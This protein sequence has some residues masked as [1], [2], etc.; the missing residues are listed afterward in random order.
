[1]QPDISR[2][3]APP[4]LVRNTLAERIRDAMAFSSHE[5]VRLPN[6]SYHCKL[7]L[8]RSS[9]QRKHQLEWLNSLCLRG[10]TK[11]PVGTQPDPSHH[12]SSRPDGLVWCRACGSWSGRG[13]RALKDRCPERAESGVQRLCLRRLARERDL[14]GLD[15]IKKKPPVTAVEA[16]ELFIIGLDPDSELSD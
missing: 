10:V 16:D 6:G 8:G 4:P 11:Q 14:P 2:A 9:V 15:H 1:M 3:P 12:L 13:F 7:C 5:V